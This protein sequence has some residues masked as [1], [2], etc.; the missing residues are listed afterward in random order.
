MSIVFYCQSCGGRFEVTPAL[1]GKKG[2]CKHCGQQMQVPRAQELASMVA[3]PAAAP[4]KE[5]TAGARAGTAQVGRRTRGEP[6]SFAAVLR[7]A[8]SSVGLEALSIDTTPLGSKKRTLAPSPLDDA[9]DSKLYELAGP[10]PNQRRGGGGAGAAAAVKRTWRR[11]VGVVQRL[12]RWLSE[13]AY[14]LSIPFIA[15]LLFGTATKSRG[16]ALFGATLVVLLN[17]GRIVAGIA[18][19]AVIPLK[20]GLNTRKMKK[21][22]RRLLEP[23]LTIA[24][25]F[26]GFAFIPWLAPERDASQTL[27]ERLKADAVGL[28]REM[29]GE[30]TGTLRKAEGIGVQGLG[31][32]AQE[33]LRTLGTGAVDEKGASS[34]RQ[35]TQE[36]RKSR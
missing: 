17:L 5:P 4:G 14:L 31:A 10:D 3:L 23:V 8:A 26:L 27:P 34:G 19:L 16:V 35:R 29:K 6:A 11:E 15:I 32:K 18:N 12:F 7:Q 25:V 9:E 21:P 2:R 24:L 28:G 33:K 30:V 20:E 36:S 13:S 1:A 22:L